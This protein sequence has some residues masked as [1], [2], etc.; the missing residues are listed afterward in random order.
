MLEKNS[1]R[2]EECCVEGAAVSETG[3]GDQGACWV[4][5]PGY[6]SSWT[7]ELWYSVSLFES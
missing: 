3:E 7:G 1:Q 5:P 2:I 6:G 4:L